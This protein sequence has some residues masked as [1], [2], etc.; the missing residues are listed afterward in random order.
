MFLK[1]GKP[2]AKGLVTWKSPQLSVQAGCGAWQNWQYNV[3]INGSGASGTSDLESYTF[4]PEPDTVYQIQVQA[5]SEGG[6]GPISNYILSTRLS[7][8]F[9]ISVL[10]N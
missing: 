3:I 10:E 1:D 7:L 6:E 5:T 2:A 4:V 9:F 8:S